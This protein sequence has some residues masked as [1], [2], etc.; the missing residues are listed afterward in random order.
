MP[1]ASI[2]DSVA[3]S[4]KFLAYVGLAALVAGSALMYFTTKKVTSP[5]MSLASLSARMS[6][7]YTHLASQPARAV[8]IEINRNKHKTNYENRHSLRG[9]CGLKYSQHGVTV[10]VVLVTA[11]E[12]CVD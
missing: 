6:V 4:N 7:S 9:L 3:V 10:Y 12:G 8:W 1:I 11:C 5:I 2:H